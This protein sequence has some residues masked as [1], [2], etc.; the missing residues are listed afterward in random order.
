MSYLAIEKD[1][2]GTPLFAALAM[3]NRGVVCA[4]LGAHAAQRPLSGHL[5]EIYNMYCR[6]DGR[7][8]NIGRNFTFSKPKGI[9]FHLIELDD[10]TIFYFALDICPDM[11]DGKYYRAQTPLP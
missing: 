3:G 11:L 2:Y 10:Q 1:R 5:T 4:F 9:L 8:F 6:D 7:D